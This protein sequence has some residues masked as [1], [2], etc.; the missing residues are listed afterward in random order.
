MSG[1]Q[2][3]THR[4]GGS[5]TFLLMRITTRDSRFAV[6]SG[7]KES[8]D[9]DDTPESSLDVGTCLNFWIN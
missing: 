9:V 6:D 3:I 4:I 5:I 1:K 8:G 2:N 7:L